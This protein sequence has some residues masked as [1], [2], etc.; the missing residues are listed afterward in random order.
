VPPRGLAIV[1]TSDTTP[2]P[3]F[4]PSGFVA[5]LGNF[6]GFIATPNAQ[7]AGGR[8][9]LI[10][11]NCVDAGAP[12]GECALF[13]VQMIVPS[14]AQAP[15]APTPDVG[16]TVHQ[17]QNGI[18][19]AWGSQQVNG[20]YDLVVTPPLAADG[21]TGTIDRYVPGATSSIGSV[22]FSAQ[23]GGQ[24]SGLAVAE[25]YGAAVFPDRGN[26]LLYAVALDG[27]GMPALAPLQDSAT[28]VY[29]EP[30]T[31]TVL[32]PFQPANANYH[33]DAWQLSGSTGKL[34]LAA[35]AAWSPPA[36]LAIDAV[37]VRTPTPGSFTCP[38]GT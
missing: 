12:A 38:G 10:T 9:N 22:T 32:M 3:A 34:S 23:G 28:V 35:K 37:A 7:T 14:A 25:C 29:Y 4:S 26:K 27:S 19:A 17:A 33:L 30:I 13:R 2:A 16:T 5:N 36:D 21:G 1:D 15:A 11:E 18:A 31:S 20:P 24:Y 8:V 6:F